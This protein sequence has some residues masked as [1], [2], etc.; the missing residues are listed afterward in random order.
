MNET[1]IPRSR[2]KSPSA[3]MPGIGE[4]VVL[5]VARIF[6]ERS[7]EARSRLLLVAMVAFRD[8]DFSVRLPTDWDGVVRLTAKPLRECGKIS[9]IR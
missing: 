1:N 8:G 3:A 2:K 5:K 9:L 7:A 4:A 6:V